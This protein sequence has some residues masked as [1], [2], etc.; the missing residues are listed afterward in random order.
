VLFDAASGL[1]G[2]PN[3][4]NVDYR[5]YVAYMTPRQFLAVNPPRDTSVRP[6]EHIQRAISVKEPIGFPILYVD[7]LPKAPSMDTPIGDWVVRGHE[8][9]GRM[10]ALS[11]IAPDSLFPVAVH[12]QGWVRARHL[13]GDDALKWIQPDRGASGPARPDVSMLGG[14]MY[15]RPGVE[16]YPA[17]VRLLDELSSQR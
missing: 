8:G 4:A 1:G 9:R 3:A 7:R 16:D 14:S 15:A 13:A 6:I 10:T 12:P 5:G 11:E 2:V 17:L